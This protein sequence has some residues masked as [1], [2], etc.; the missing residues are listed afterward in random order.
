MQ[1]ES[2]FGSYAVGNP[3]Y[4]KGLGNAAAVLGDDGTLEDLDPLSRSFLDS[5]VDLDGISDL[6]RKSVV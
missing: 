4:G 3:S 1:G 6:D 5:V 2:L